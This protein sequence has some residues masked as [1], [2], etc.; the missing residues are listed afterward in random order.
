MLFVMFQEHPD[1]DLW[2]HV[3]PARVPPSEREQ[4][5]EIPRQGAV[6]AHL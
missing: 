6:A 5:E 1:W 3:F 2:N 4:V